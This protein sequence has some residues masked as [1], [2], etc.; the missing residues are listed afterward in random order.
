MGAV[1]AA[2]ESPSQQGFTPSRPRI[3]VVCE[4]NRKGEVEQFLQKLF[5]GHNEPGRRC[6][7]PNGWVKTYRLQGK[8]VRFFSAEG[9]GGGPEAV[10][11]ARARAER[12]LEAHFAQT[13]Q[14]G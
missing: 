13:V 5:E 1:Q 4:R 6:F 3:C 10:E 2:V 7:F 9:T 12:A 14:S 11:A 8:D